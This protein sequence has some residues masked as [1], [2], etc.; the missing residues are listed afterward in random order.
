[1]LPA[2][3]GDPSSGIHFIE[4]KLVEYSVVGRP[5]NPEAVNLAMN[6]DKMVGGQFEKGLANLNAH[7]SK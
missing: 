6:C 4:Q 3:D 5:A 1:M 2:K 7:L